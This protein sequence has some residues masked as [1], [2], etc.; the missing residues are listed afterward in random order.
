MDGTRF[1][2]GDALFTSLNPKRRLECF[3]MVLRGLSEFPEEAQ[4]EPQVGMRHPRPF[5]ARYLTP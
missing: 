4:A 2:P 5:I 3:L 1:T